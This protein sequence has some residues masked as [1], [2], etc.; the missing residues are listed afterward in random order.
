MLAKKLLRLLIVTFASLGI[1]TFCVTQ[2][3]ALTNEEKDYFNRNNIIYYNPD[4]TDGCIDASAAA[5]ISGST[6]AEKA[7]TGF[8]SVGFTAEQ[9]AAIMGNIT[10]ESGFNPFKVNSNASG[11]KSQYSW[12]DLLTNVGKATGIMQWTGCKTCDSKRKV[13]MLESLNQNFRQYFL[14]P[15]KYSSMSTND[16]IADIGEQT[17]DAVL[18]EEIAFAKQEIDK[19]DRYQ[20]FLSG[21][22]IEDMAYLF[23]VWNE[24]PGKTIALA[25][26][27]C[28]TTKNGTDRSIAARQYYDLY[29]D[30][31]A[32]ES[33][34]NSDGSASSF[35]SS[36]GSN[37]T[38][39]G[40]SLT[41][42]ISKTSAIKK[43]K[44]GRKV[45]GTNAIKGLN[46]AYVNAKE[47]RHWSTGQD[48][49]EDLEKDGK[50]TDIVV[51]ALGTNDTGG[52]TEEQIKKVYKTVGD[53]RKL[54]FVTNFT[55]VNNESTQNNYKKTNERLKAFAEKHENVAIIDYASV[56]GNNAGKFIG[57][58]NIHLTSDGQQRFRELL[59]S[60]IG[61]NMGTSSSGSYSI[62]ESGYA[63]GGTWTEGDLPWY[64]QCDDRWG[65]LR[66]G[67]GGIHGNTGSTICKA[68]CGP[69]SFAMLVTALLGKEILPDQTTDIAGK[70]NMYV[71][72]EG[73]AHGITKKLANHFGLEYKNIS[74]C[75]NPKQAIND[76]L[77]DG[78]MVHTSGKGSAP[79]SQNGHYIGIAGFTPDGKWMVAD[80]SSYTKKNAAY[81][82][83]TVVNAGLWCSNIHAIR[84]K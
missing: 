74:N 6:A 77:N 30:L 21:S 52:V 39:I 78:W 48:I 31:N 14:E 67:T 9:T 81:N 53:K 20:K 59:A 75:T 47:S 4:G 5:E 46:K 25:E 69:T 79:F 64:R 26:R 62:C 58:D 32:S 45:D 44:D 24:T 19:T 34:S 17:Y 40:D 73:S 84:A 12:D 61:S 10:N 3:S 68:G 2:A 15:A 38:I 71:P 42:G 80:S 82:P 33:D 22:S 1:I 16:I 57:N 27:H 28:S 41:V 35:S 70:A 50:L 66:F 37:V 51:F 56:I 36:D 11:L 13:Y 23:C 63:G 76:A 18:A 7:W 83:D 54:F 65:N 60:S 43:E 29:K 72:G 49:L 55:K 8:R